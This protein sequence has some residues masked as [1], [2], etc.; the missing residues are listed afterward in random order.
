MKTRMPFQTFHRSIPVESTFPFYQKKTGLSDVTNY[1]G[2]QK[3]TKYFI[4]SPYSLTLT[5]TNT[6]IE[7]MQIVYSSSKS[8]KMSHLQQHYGVYGVQLVNIFP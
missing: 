6:E 4:Y 1:T 7:L 5:G 3:T 8:S 2:L